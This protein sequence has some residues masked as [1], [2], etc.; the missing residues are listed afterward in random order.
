MCMC[1]ILAAERDDLPPEVRTEVDKFTDINVEWLTHALSPAVGDIAPESTRRRALA[2]LAAI[3]GHSWSRA[4]A[5]MSPPT[6]T[7]SKPTAAPLGSFHS[8]AA[9]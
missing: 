3:D 2:I 1:G 6:M 7:Q 8:S 9:G 5:E 4:A